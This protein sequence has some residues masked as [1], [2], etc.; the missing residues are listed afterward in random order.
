MQKTIIAIITI[1]SVIVLW[2]TTG[3]SQNASDYL[4]CRD[5]GNFKKYGCT[6]GTGAG[7]LVPADHFGGDHND[8]SCTVIYHSLTQRMGVDVE[9][10]Q[11]SGVDSDRWLLHEVEG[12]FRRN[13][14]QSRFKGMLR[15]INGSRIF[16]YSRGT[17]YSWISNNIVVDIRYTDLQKTKPEPL[18]IIQA[19]LQKHSST[20]PVMT[21]DTAHDIVWIKDEMER[22]LWLCDKWFMQLQLGKVQ[23]SQVLQE[24]VKSMNIFLDYREKYYSMAAVSEKNLLAGYL[25]ANNGTGI[26]TKLAE[27]KTWWQ[28]NRSAAISL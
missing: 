25:N 20:L 9:V 10:T 14:E 3:N 4:V 11:H 24:A 15:E 8:I 18:E 2:A 27:Y 23:E 28:A 13:P 19:Y 12:N 7:I 26:R 1:T 21:M 6:C 5:I 16:T 22:R 17:H